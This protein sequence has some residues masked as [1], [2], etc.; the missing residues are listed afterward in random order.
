V[1]GRQLK[2]GELLDDWLSSDSLP[3]NQIRLDPVL[4][5]PLA[6]PIRD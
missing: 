2:S 5:T 4:M 6:N 3:L 1:N